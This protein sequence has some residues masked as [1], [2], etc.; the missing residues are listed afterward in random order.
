MFLEVNIYFLNYEN[1]L[2]KNGQF[3][4]FRG[5][6]SA[7]RYCFY[8]AWI[9]LFSQ[10]YG[11]KLTLLSFYSGYSTKTLLWGN[12][13]L[14]IHIRAKETP[15]APPSCVKQRARAKEKSKLFATLIR[16]FQL[17][18]NK[19]SGLRNLAW[20]LQ[21]AWTRATAPRLQDP[22][23]SIQSG[24]INFPLAISMP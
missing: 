15:L 7:W 22:C 21:A 4:S 2:A 12:L 20:L 9:L 14:Y 18:K 23:H 11:Q 3:A 8:S 1:N 16:R 24:G 13:G 5:L 17:Y 19:W 10:S 6:Y